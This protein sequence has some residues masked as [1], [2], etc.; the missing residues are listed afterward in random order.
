MKIVI[1]KCFGGFGLS[2]EAIMLYAKLKKFKL[3][4]FTEKRDKEGKINF[5]IFEKYNPKKHKASFIHYSKKP[6][7][8]NGKYVKLSYFSEHD[9]DRTDNCLIR[10]VEQ[11]GEK[12]NGDYAELKIIE[13][14]DGIN[15]E[16]S[17]YDG[18][19]SIEECHNS[20][21]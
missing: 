8:K 21:S 5:N 4:A 10:A 16:I 11:L 2:Y 15:Y 18:I 3:Y 9:I 19:E 6:L 14:P 13:I 1:N 12:A 17:E 20:W 7:C